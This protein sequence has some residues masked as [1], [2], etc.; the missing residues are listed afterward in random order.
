M[1]ESALTDT[2]VL[3]VNTTH[4]I[5]NTLLLIAFGASVVQLPS[6]PFNF[7]HKYRMSSGQV[8]AVATVVTKKHH[9]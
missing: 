5:P 7:P 2:T 8:I 9:R 3:H 6:F 4:C 1:C